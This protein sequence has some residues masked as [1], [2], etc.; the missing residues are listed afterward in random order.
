[1]LLVLRV[2]LLELRRKGRLC[3]GGNGGRKRRLLRL[4][5]LDVESLFQRLR[6]LVL[7]LLLQEWITTIYPLSVIQGHLHCSL[8]FKNTSKSHMTRGL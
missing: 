5:G 8:A 2:R 4:L 1:M 6:K 7:A 3:G